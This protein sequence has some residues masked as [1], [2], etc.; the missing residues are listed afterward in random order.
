M[1]GMTNRFDPIPYRQVHHSGIVVADLDAAEARYHALGFAD[2]HRFAVESQGI[3]AITFPCSDGYVELI[4]PTDPEGA[5]AR[6]MAK[7]GEGVHHIA[8]RVDD[9]T[10]V[11]AE[12]KF[13]GVRLIDEQPRSGAH[14]WKVAFIHPEACCGVL[15]ELVE[16]PSDGDSH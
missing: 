13:R 1:D 16:A 11:L 7:R 10:A 3:E 14:G 6:F 2:G 15:T 12:L 9:I 8:Y 5:I 4:C